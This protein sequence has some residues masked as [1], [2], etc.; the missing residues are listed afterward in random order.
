ME[1]WPAPLLI[2]G[3]QRRTDGD[4]RAEPATGGVDANLGFGGAWLLVCQELRIPAIAADA[5]P[6]L[7]ASAGRYRVLSRRGGTGALCRRTQNGAFVSEDK[8]TLT[9]DLKLDD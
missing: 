9:L 6:A 2:L 4:V 3:P 5:K 1:G 7:D 8:P